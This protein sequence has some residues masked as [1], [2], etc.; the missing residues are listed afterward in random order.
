MVQDS[1][2]HD[3]SR[4]KF[5]SLVVSGVASVIAV[6]VA[7]P[8][9][10]YFLSPAWKKDKQITI[11][12]AQTSAIP[13]GVPTYVRYEERVP[14]AW[15]ITTETKGVWIVT[16]DGKNFV[17]FDPHCTH[18]NCP[19]YWDDKSQIFRC[20][21]HG[22]DFDIN[23]NVL[24]GPLPRPLDRLEFIIEGGEIELTGRIIREG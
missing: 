18:L 24:A 20:P 15:V 16:Q 22:G 23:G 5:L 4:R 13:L 21:C 10:S 2:G 17:V 11:P 1:S 6:V 14:D 8:L 9:V 3:V 19:Y 7:I 12:V